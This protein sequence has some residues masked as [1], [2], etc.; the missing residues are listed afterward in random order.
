M[1]TTCQNLT[2]AAQCN[3]RVNNFCPNA[4]GTDAPRLSEIPLGYFP[5]ATCIVS[6]SLS[7]SLCITCFLFLTNSLDTHAVS[8][9]RGRI[10]PQGQRVIKSLN[11]YAS[12]TA[13]FFIII[14]EILGLCSI[15]HLLDHWRPDPRQRYCQRRSIIWFPFSLKCTHPDEHPDSA[16]ASSLHQLHELALSFSASAGGWSKCFWG[17]F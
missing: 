12:R 4:T 10:W 17:I 15:Y 1:L 2:V 3:A 5:W 13:L 8:T 7:L 14:M 11:S 16:A 6:L 9:G